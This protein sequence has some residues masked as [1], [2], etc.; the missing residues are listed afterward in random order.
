VVI[1]ILGIGSHFDQADSYDPLS[2]ANYC[3]LP[4]LSSHPDLQFTATQAFDPPWSTT[5]PDFTD[6]IAQLG[7]VILPYSYNAAFFGATSASFKVCS[8]GQ[9]DSGVAS[10][11]WST[12]RAA[13]NHWLPTRRRFVPSRTRY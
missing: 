12:C 9:F 10:W 4:A 6:A 8:Y 3:N 1:L 5:T 13:L 2:M 11:T 7:A